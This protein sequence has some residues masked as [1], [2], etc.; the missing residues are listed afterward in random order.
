LPPLLS[1]DDI[2]VQLKAAMGNLPA[3]TDPK[4]SLGTVFKEFYSKI[5]KSAVDSKLVKQRAQELVAVT[6]KS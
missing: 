6:S 5:D 1:A 2:D 3:G 4:K